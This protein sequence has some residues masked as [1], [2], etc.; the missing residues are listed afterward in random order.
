MY[1]KIFETCVN[2]SFCFSE[3]DDDDDEED[4]GDAESDFEQLNK[5]FVAVDEGP[6]A[7]EIE[8]KRRLNMLL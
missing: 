3:V 7:K 5:D 4:V 1:S 6:S 2:E 8:G